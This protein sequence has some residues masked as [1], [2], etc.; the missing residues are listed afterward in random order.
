MIAAMS[1]IQT[2]TQSRSKHTRL[3]SKPPNYSIKGGD[4]VMSV[5]HGLKETRDM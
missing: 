3:S 2:L 1:P 4:F 5:I